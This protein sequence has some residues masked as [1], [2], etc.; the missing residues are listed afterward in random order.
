MLFNRIT[1]GYIKAMGLI[2]G[3]RARTE[4]KRAERKRE[5]YSAFGHAV[6]GRHYID[7]Q[8]RADIDFLVEGISKAEDKAERDGLLKLLRAQPVK[9]VPVKRAER[10]DYSRYSGADIR[11]LNKAGGGKK[12]QARAAKRVAAM[13]PIKDDAPVLAAA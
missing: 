6:H 11:S 7:P 1:E 4:K 5:V 10:L 3:T 9:F 8:T 12:E 2:M 13:K